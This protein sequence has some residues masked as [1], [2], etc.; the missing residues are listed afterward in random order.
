MCMSLLHNSWDLPP[1]INCK[2]TVSL[3]V[4]DIVE[5]PYAVC[6]LVKPNT[7]MQPSR[8]YNQG[9]VVYLPLAALWHT[10]Y[11]TSVN[12]TSNL[13]AWCGGTQ[14]KIALFCNGY[15]VFLGFYRF[16]GLDKDDNICLLLTEDNS[17]LC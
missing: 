14:S 5:L 4:W 13:H 7:W 15:F 17:T 8:L 12:A 10:P 6:R 9:W 16:L 11:L 1:F 3:V 2:M